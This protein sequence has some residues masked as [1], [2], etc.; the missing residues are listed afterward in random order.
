MNLHITGLPDSV[1]AEATF[2]AFIRRCKMRL[3]M[4]INILGGFKGSTTGVTA[5]SRVL[6]W[7]L[8]VFKNCWIYLNFLSLLCL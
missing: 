5:K 3:I 1:I 2:K 7:I 6:V 4:I 8:W